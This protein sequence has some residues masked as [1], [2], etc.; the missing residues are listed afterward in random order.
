M[1]AAT[2]WQRVIDAI[3]TAMSYASG[4]NYNIEYTI[5]RVGQNSRRVRAKGKALFNDQQQSTR[6]SGIL[7][8]VTAASD[9]HKDTNERLELTLEQ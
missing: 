4:G 2:D 8:D 7:Q 5:E 1:I 6:F 3:N 9:E